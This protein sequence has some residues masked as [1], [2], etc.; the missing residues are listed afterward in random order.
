[1]ATKNPA[2]PVSI[3]RA[4]NFAAGRCNALCAQ[5]L[6][7]HGLTLPQWVVLSC[8]WRDGPLSV[9]TLAELTGNGLPATSR[10][11]DRMSDRGLVRRTGKGRDARTVMI[12][13][14]D[15]GRTLDHLADF[16]QRVN[17]ALLHGFSPEERETALRMLC[18]IRENAMDQLK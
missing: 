1:M 9:S 3:G 10:I 2:P 17:D 12:D 11:I 14:T 15:A 7:P 16:H 13:V 5:W 4:L 18:R 8:I 6:E